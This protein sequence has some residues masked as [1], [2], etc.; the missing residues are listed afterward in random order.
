M[1]KV[2][3]NLTLYVTMLYLSHG[4]AAQHGVLY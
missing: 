3:F 4:L 2:F 1:V